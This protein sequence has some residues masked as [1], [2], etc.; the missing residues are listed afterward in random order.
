[1]FQTDLK[2]KSAEKRGAFCRLIKENVV[3]AVFGPIPVDATEKEEWLK[4][5]EAEA[6]AVSAWT[7]RLIC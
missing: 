2:K 5:H 6:N 1:M 4:R 3:A 7:G